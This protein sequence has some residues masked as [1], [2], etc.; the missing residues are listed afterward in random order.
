[1]DLKYFSLPQ[2]LHT[3]DRMSMALSTEMRVPFLDFEL[4]ENILP[5]SVDSK[6]KNG[7][8]KY[9]FRKSMENFL[10]S[11]IVWRRDKQN[12]GNAQG[13]LLKGSL[14]KEIRSNYFSPDSLIFKKEIMRQSELIKIYEKYISQPANRGLVSYKE[15]FAPIS[16]EIWL[17]K[18]E[19]YIN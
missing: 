19:N 10:P 4:V 12:F 11:D 7:W 18:F 17:R 3:E 15:I 2:L 6:L 9:V 16:L 13:E 1:M 8:T 14:S 5:L